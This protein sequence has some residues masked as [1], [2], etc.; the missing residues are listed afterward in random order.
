MINSCYKYLKIILIIIFTT[1][2]LAL[3]I[4]CSQPE[5]PKYV[6]TECP[7]NINGCMSE[8]LVVNGLIKKSEPFS[9]FYEAERNRM[10]SHI[11]WIQEPSL[12]LGE[13]ITD[14]TTNITKLRQIPPDL[15]DAFIVAHELRSY[16]YWDDGFPSITYDLH[17]DK[18]NL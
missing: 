2:I 5:L 15:N 1:L 11:H 13:A 14:C 6:I 10:P 9:K 4:G 18:F 3:Q 7:A 8:E 16:V 12:K 17:F